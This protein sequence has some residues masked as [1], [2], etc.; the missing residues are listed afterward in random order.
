[1][2]LPTVTMSGKQLVAREAPHVRAEPPEA[3]LHLVG[4][5]DAAGL[6]HHLHGRRGI[7]PER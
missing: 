2:S 5:E 7:R 6:A 1:M 3:G 4:D